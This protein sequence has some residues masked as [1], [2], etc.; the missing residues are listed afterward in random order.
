MTKHKKRNNPAL[1]L[2]IIVDLIL[3]I[4]ILLLMSYVQFLL[5]KDIRINLT[6]IVTQ[7]KDVITSRLKLELNNMDMTSRQLA[8]RFAAAEDKS[9]ESYKTIFLDYVSQQE[10]ASYSW[11]NAEGVAVFPGGKVVDISGRR[12]FRLAMDGIQNISERTVSRLTGE[13]IFVISVPLK[14]GDEVVGTVQQ[15]YTPEEMYNLCA[16]SLYSEQGNIYI[17]NSDGYILIS[18]QNGNYDLESDNLYRMIYLTDPKVS[19][20]LEADIQVG[21]SG[22]FETAINGE[23]TFSAYTPIEEVYDWF[24][25]SSVATSAVSA[26]ANIVIKLFYCILLVL[27]VLFSFSMFYFLRMKKK[28]QIAL[29]K[30]AFEDDVT[31]GDTY[32]KFAVRWE[33]TLQHQPEGEYALLALDIDN[34]KY[35][36]SFYGFETGDNALCS[37]YQRYHA[38][39][40]DGE[41]M[42]RISGDHFVVLL[43]D[44]SQ[45]RLSTFFEPE[46]FVD[47]IKIYVSAG[48]YPIKDPQETIN[49][50]MDKANMAVRHTKNKQQ[51]VVA[52]YSEVDDQKMI[53]NEQLKRSMELAI[54]RDE[55]LPYFQ[56]KVDVFTQELVGAEA[57][58]RWETQDGALVPPGTFIPLCEETGLITVLDTI[59]FEKTLQFLRKNLDAGVDCVPI[60]VNFSRRHLFDKNFL[61]VILTKL[62]EYQVPASL[63]ELELTET[64]FFDNYQNINNF[65]SELHKHGFKV[66]MDDFGSGYSSLNML[67]DVNID[68]LK[69]DRGF[70]RGTADS[71]RQKAVFGAIVQ[72]AKKLDI[73]VVVEGVEFPEN[74]ALLKEFDC[75]IA[76]GFYYAKPMN[77]KAFGKVCREGILG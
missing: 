17:I 72:M 41:F 58:A 76:Q 25:I 29:E 19:K 34:F 64:I 30:L 35:I 45:K 60:S 63:I 7:N 73:K 77:Q 75:R 37:L 65:I 43:K 4:S 13:D 61:E 50:M 26:N 24:L 6:E 23:K 27:V 42:A 44:A 20:T 67:Q 15:Q 39:L 48:L 16:I 71:E 55:I 47:G 68:V 36:N 9:Q 1:L 2:V 46:M 56:P 66:S 10:N 33:E 5:E 32:T 22:F 53:F 52:V 12:Y 62:A 54:A 49:L 51:K 31:G 59:I 21:D 28:Q 69:I 18:S 57:L 70:L 11:A 3:L 14:I 74:V 38:K 40:K 8:E